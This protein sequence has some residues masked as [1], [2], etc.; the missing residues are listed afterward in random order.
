MFG[1]WSQ[2]IIFVIAIIG[3]MI[4]R[5]N[6]INSVDAG[7][8]EMSY[9]RVSRDNSFHQ[10]SYSDRGDRGQS[11]YGAR[12]PFGFYLVTILCLVIPGK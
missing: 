2:H 11:A 4:P 6:E 1:A 8:S 9:Q 12:P 10:Q 7:R 5:T 3:S